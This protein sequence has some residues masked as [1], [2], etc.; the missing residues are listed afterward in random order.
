MISVREALLG[1]VLVAAFGVGGMCILTYISASIITEAHNKIDATRV[2]LQRSED[3]FTAARM[4]LQ[5]ELNTHHETRVDLAE[6]RKQANKPN[7]QLTLGVQDV[8]R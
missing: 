7:S 4:I 3:A 8:K 5:T 6:C 1:A 2:E